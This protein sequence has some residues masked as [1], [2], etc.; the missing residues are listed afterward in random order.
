[1]LGVVCDCQMLDVKVGTIPAGDT[2]VSVFCDLVWAR[3]EVE[4]VP[5]SLIELSQVYRDSMTSV[6]L[7]DIIAHQPPAGTMDSDSVPAGREAI[8]SNCIG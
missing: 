8:K 3:V 5:L 7:N 1:M 6:S 2:R 4:K